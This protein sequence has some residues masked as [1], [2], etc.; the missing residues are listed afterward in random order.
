MRAWWP[1]RCK[2][3]RERP[4]APWLL[5]LYVFFLL[6]LGLPYVNWASQKCCLFYLRSSLHSLDLPLFCFCGLFSSLSFSHHHSGLLFPVLTTSHDKRH[7]CS[8]YSCMWRGCLHWLSGPGVEEGCPPLCGPQLGSAV[9]NAL[10]FYGL[11]PGCLPL[12]L[13]QAPGQT[14]EKLGSTHGCRWYRD[15]SVPR[16]SPLLGLLA[17]FHWRGLFD[18]QPQGEDGG[19]CISCWIGLQVS[20]AAEIPETPLGCGSQI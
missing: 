19:G 1:K 20:V 2:E 15:P 4:P 8:V 3:K 11:S 14:G 9:C 13:G 17:V 12:L 5:I 6:P 18:P 7:Y 10:M 16:C